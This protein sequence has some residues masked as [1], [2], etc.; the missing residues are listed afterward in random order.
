MVALQVDKIYESKF[1]QHWKNS[2]QQK[3]LQLLSLQDL[4]MLYSLENINF[5][6]KIFARRTLN[7]IRKNLNLAKNP[8]IR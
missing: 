1:L 2:L 7:L 3:F 6:P 4:V 8:A 5:Q